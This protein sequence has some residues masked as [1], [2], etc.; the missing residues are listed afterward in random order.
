MYQQHV[1]FEAIGNGDVLWKYLDLARYLN[2][3]L[4]KQLFFCRADR[5][6]D[7][8]EGRLSQV[9][10]DKSRPSSPAGAKRE[11]PA[12]STLKREHV[13]LNS[14]HLNTAEN[15]AM[16]KIYAKGDDGLA[17]Q[18]TYGRLKQSFQ[19]SEL[20]VFIGRVSYYDETDS[21]KELVDPFAPFLRKRAIYQY[22]NEVRCCYQLPADQTGFSWQA[23]GSENG[24]FITV[25]L[26]TLIERIYIS[27]FSPHWISEIVAG[28]N[29]KFGLDKE[30]IHSTVFEGSDY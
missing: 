17:I 25:D 22:E 15:Y 14:W 7:P 18:T 11:I 21:E 16:W 27:P 24:I 1:S 2:L 26:E 10:E 4:K 13:T 19:S 6:E 28:L 23:Q 9:E 8:F 5:F 29:A 3:L 20:P 12:R 30:I